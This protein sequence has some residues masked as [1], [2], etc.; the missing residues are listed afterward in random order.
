M[1]SPLK[2]VSSLL[3]TGHP[4]LNDLLVQARWAA[5]SRECEHPSR[6]RG[7]LRIN[8]DVRRARRESPSG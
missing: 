5:L 6:T 4:P 1:Y 7:S 8:L 2:T 3:N